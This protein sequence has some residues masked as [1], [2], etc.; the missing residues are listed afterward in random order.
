[1]GG[2]G[3]KGKQSKIKAGGEGN[4]EGTRPAQMRKAKQQKGK[5]KK[6]PS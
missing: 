3:G 1:V 6:S 4:N 5:K 2:E